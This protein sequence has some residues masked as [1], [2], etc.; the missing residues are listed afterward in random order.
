MEKTFIPL[1]NNITIKGEI[2]MGGDFNCV[3]DVKFDRKDGAGTTYHVKAAK[4]LSPYLKS[5]NL[6]DICHKNNK[7]KNGGFTWYNH[8]K[9]IASRIDRIYLQPNLTTLVRD[10]RIEMSFS[11]HKAVIIEIPSLSNGK[12][13]EGFWKMNTSILNGLEFKSKIGGIRKKI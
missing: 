13:G 4:I 12:H 11:D 8:D 2:I 1:L 5:K 9:S 6:K 10:V 7:N 3:E